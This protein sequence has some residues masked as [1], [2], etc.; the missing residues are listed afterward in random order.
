MGNPYS[1]DLRLRVL[2]AID[3]GKS[4]MAAHKTFGVSR[5]TIDDW[6]ELRARTG[7]VA[8]NTSYRR[9][10]APGV[11]EEEF[12]AFALAHSGCTLEQMSGAWHEQKGQKRSTKYF[13]RGLARIG[14]TRKKRVFSIASAAK[15]HVAKKHAASS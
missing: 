13:S 15:K 1:E 2:Q 5:S 8:A 6:I 3:S 9:G 11:S 4:K 14:W 7:S 12:R 10:K